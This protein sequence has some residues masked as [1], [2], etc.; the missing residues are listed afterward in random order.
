[1]ISVR[2]T[3]LTGER[4]DV[5]LFRDWCWLGTADDAS[6]LQALLEAPPRAAF[7]L[8]IYRILCKRLPRLQV[9][10]FPRDSVAAALAPPHA[11]KWAKLRRRS[12]TLELM[13]RAR[14]ARASQTETAVGRRLERA[15]QIVADAAYRR[16]CR[17]AATQP[18]LTLHTR[19]LIAWNAGALTY[20]SFA[21]LAVGRADVAM[22]RV[23][24]QLYDQ[25]GYV[26]FLLVVV[27]STASVVAIGFLVGDAK[28]TAYSPSAAYICRY[29]FW[30]S[31]YPG[32]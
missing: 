10:A 4:T 31:C 32:C 22:T 17:F 20:L 14:F 23:R 18:W 24:A 7:D 28:T 29:R 9:H 12:C 1:M 30:R 27:A 6:S 5:H 8:D 3:S 25:T 21:W 13:T 15:A 16:D 11:E 2:E 19:L 26:I